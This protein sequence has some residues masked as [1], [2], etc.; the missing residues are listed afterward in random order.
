MGTNESVRRRLSRNGSEHEWTREQ[1]SVCSSGDEWSRINESACGP[2]WAR[3]SVALIGLP[4]G[5][6]RI[7]ACWL[8][9]SCTVEHN[10]TVTK[11]SFNLPV[12]Y[13]TVTKGPCMLFFPITH[14][15]GVVRGGTCSNYS[16]HRRILLDKLQGLAR[17][18]VRPR[19]GITEL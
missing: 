15:G 5:H 17:S 2:V 3:V 18:S 7:P 10:T 9:L 14:W 13:I 4:N 6:F 1:L 12:Q 16:A 19:F 11:A 8:T